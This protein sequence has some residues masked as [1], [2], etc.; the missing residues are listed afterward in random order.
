MIEIN[1][2]INIMIITI[3]IK[4]TVITIEMIRISME[5]I[6]GRRGHTGQAARWGGGA[7]DQLR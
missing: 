2:N 6:T 5:K 4:I 7:G 1:I 3:I